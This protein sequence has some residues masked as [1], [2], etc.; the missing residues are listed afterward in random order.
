MWV[1]AMALLVTAV[2][3]LWRV[4]EPGRVPL[5]CCAVLSIVVNAAAGLQFLWLATV[6]AG[7]V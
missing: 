6:S 2:A 3:S 1:G 7:G 5:L 4:K